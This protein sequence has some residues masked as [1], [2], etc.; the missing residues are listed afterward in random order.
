MFNQPMSFLALDSSYQGGWGKI[1]PQRTKEEF[2]SKKVFSPK[3]EFPSK[4]EFPYGWRYVEKTWKNGQTITEKIPLTQEDILNPQLGDEMPEN[5]KH[6]KCNVDLFG[7]FY[8]RYRNDPN[9]EVFGDFIF[10]WGIPDL[11]K[12]APDVAVVQ[13]SKNKDNYRSS[14]DVLEEGTRPS[15]VIEIVSPSS[16]KNDL[17]KKVNI[18]RQAQV[19]EYFIVDPHLEKG[20]VCYEINGYHL[21]GK[22]YLKIKPDKQ[23]RFFS[24]T[25]QVL[26]GVN[27]ELDTLKLWDANTGSEILLTREEI[28]DARIEAEARA[29]IETKARVEA[30]AHA[31]TEAK[32]RAKAEARAETEA[33]ARAEEAKARADAEARAEALEK[34]LRELMGG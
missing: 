21:V 27:D 1:K 31:K 2:L 7:V 30:E 3:R 34:Q 20:K 13:N 29:K 4:E 17:E 10:K 16:K 23:G 22:R 28:E 6:F 25:T 15:L 19:E 8:T 14:F 11:E 24:K 12:P 26:L 9:T 5:N 18:Y 32:A 33:K